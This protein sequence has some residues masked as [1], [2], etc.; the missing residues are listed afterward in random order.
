M[1]KRTK[2][3]LGVFLVSYLLFGLFL[4]LTQER[5]I[6]HPWPQ[7]FAACDA[8]ADAE[9]VT[10]ADTRMYAHTGPRGVVVLY[11]GN[12]GSAC[13]RAHYAHQFTDAG[14]GYVLVEYA[15][16]SNDA[17]SPSHDLMK[18][19]VR[20]VIS[21]LSELNAPRVVVV[22]ESVGTGA[23]SYHASLRVPDHL[24]LI[25]PFA[26]LVDVAQRRFWFYPASLLVYNAFDNMA[27]LAQ[28]RGSI[29]IVHGDND[30]VISQKSG[31]RLFEHLETPDKHF[32]SVQGKGHNDLPDS[33]E[34]H[35]VI[36]STIL[37][38][39]KDT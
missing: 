34:L 19:D 4:T 39:E 22:G 15:G 6:Y 29:T 14:Y 16:Y 17:R 18:Q 38:S 35:E 9:K 27:L 3:A 11:H 26:S 28:N 36:R 32:V 24:L 5:M 2:I 1:Q 8:L 30:L 25:S 23:A 7:D 21:Y 10:Y 31:I 13:D 37:A 12:T 33:T 20:N